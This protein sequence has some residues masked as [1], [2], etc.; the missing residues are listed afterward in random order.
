MAILAAMLFPV[1]KSAR[2]RA[3]LSTCQSNLT[4]IS[5]A[6][7]MYA[8]ENEDTYPTNRLADGTVSPEVPLC[9]RAGG[10]INVFEY[11][12]NWVEALYKYS[13]PAGKGPQSSSMWTC[14]AASNEGT[15]NTA[16]NTYALNI[17]MIERPET[18]VRSPGQ[19]MVVREMSKKC[20]S[21]CRPV[22]LNPSQRPQNTFLT[23][24][25]VT[26]PSVSK[27]HGSGSNILFADGHVK[28]YAAGGTLTVRSAPGTGTA[29]RVELPCR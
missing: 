25:D 7:K 15:R 29:V 6:L 21:V 17:N 22:N 20:G 2:A 26:G 4:Q 13:E 1:Y 9:S 3:K 10:Q 11:G 12:P 8:D 28:Q 23:D 18:S 27:L 5:K 24:A 19:T 14:P 16:A